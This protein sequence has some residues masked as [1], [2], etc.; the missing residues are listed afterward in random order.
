MYFCVFHCES[1]SKVFSI[2]YTAGDESLYPVCPDCGARD[3]SRRYRQDF[4]MTG[5][6]SMPEMI[7]DETDLDEPDEI[8]MEITIRW[9]DTQA[10][11]ETSEPEK[12]VKKTDES[13]TNVPKKRERDS[14][15]EE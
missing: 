8:P 14:S 2:F 7:A 12:P 10:D 11:Q 4:D 9:I 6:Q 3:L 5:R 15:G 1:C 13:G